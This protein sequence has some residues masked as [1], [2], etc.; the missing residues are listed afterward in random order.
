MKSRV[1]PVV[2]LA[3]A[4]LVSQACEKTPVVMP[5]PPEGMEVDS[6]SFVWMRINVKK[7]THVKEITVEEDSSYTIVLPDGDPYVYLEPFASG[8]PA[9]NTVFAF[10][11]KAENPIDKTEFFFVDGEDG[12][13]ASHAQ[14]GQGAAPTVS[15]A[16]SMSFIP[17]VFWNPS[18]VMISFPLISK[19]GT[20]QLSVG[21][22]ST[23]T[24]Q[25]PHMFPLQ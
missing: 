19:A 2:C 8:L 14:S 23:R 1:L 22:P 5:A 20:M 4:F 18:N 15:Y 21:L 12:L 3:A 13:D 6:S 17:L 10:E 9:E 16:F 24:A 11:Y 7:S 25:R